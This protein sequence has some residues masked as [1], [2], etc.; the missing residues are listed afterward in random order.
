MFFEVSKDTVA[1]VEKVVADPEST[2][3][4]V[5]S[6]PAP[7]VKNNMKDPTQSGAIVRRRGGVIRP[8]GTA[9]GIQ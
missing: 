4:P 9:V 3:F 8:C 5:D 6:V 7:S 2:V 1:K